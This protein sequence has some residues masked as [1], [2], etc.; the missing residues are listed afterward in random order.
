MSNSHALLKEN[1]QE[2]LDVLNRYSIGYDSN[3]MA[4]LGA[5]FNE[6]A[7]TGGRVMG[8]DVSWGEWQ[9]R[10]LIVKELAAIRNS[11]EDRRRHVITSAIFED[12]SEHAATV[13]VYL[14]LFSYVSPT[15]PKL[16]TTGDYIMKVSDKEGSWKMDLLKEVLDSPF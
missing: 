3:D 15:K 4:L 11:Q 16:V 9:G 5:A 14:A 12:I 13:R 1:R 7:I 6:N 2:I 10:D 8:T